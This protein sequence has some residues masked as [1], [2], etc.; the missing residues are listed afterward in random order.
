[1]AQVQRAFVRAPSLGS[2]AAV[3]L[4]GRRW[5]RGAPEGTTAWLTTGD[6]KPMQPNQGLALSHVQLPAS[7]S[8]GVCHATGVHLR[9]RG[10]STLPCLGGSCSDASRRGTPH[11][12][13]ILLLAAGILPY[14]ELPTVTFATRSARAS[15]LCPFGS[16]HPQ[17]GPDYNTLG[18]C[19]SPQCS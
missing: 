8:S 11:G 9:A 7:A 15:P 16:H 18:P 2:A 19:L 1:M 12:A 6:G 3:T 17:G 14:G 10:A 13:D 4:V 5:A